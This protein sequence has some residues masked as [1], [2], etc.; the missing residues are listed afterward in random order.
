MGSNCWSGS[1]GKLPVKSVGDGLNA[2][3]AQWSF[4]FFFDDRLAWKTS[5]LAE[6]SLDEGDDDIDGSLNVVCFDRMFLTTF[7]SSS[8][9]DEFPSSS[10]SP[11]G[12]GGERFDG[13]VMIERSSMKHETALETL[14]VQLTK[15]FWRQLCLRTLNDRRADQPDPVHPLRILVV[16]VERP[17]TDRWQFVESRTMQWL[18]I[19][20]WW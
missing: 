9:S 7:L 6:P 2:F 19:H 8:D 15:L 17:L 14:R 10:L 13:L 12:I 18:V 1:G 11:L 16:F 20:H 3:F 4:F 5:A